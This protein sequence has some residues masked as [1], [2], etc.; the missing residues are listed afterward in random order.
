MLIAVASQNFHTVTGH[1]GM[2]RRF[3]VFNAEKGQSPREVTR[4]DLP[5]DQSIHEFKGE[6]HPL[7][8]VQVLIAGS[9]GAGFI[10]R[11][12]ARGVTTVVTSEID[13]ATAVANYLAGTLAAPEPHNHDH[14]HDAEAGGCCCGSGAH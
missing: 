2:A 5:K 12:T 9:A 10:D 6:S 8:D 1:A 14:D 13:P 3:I 4:L 7:D 11:M